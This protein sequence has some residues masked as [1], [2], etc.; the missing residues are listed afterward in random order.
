[1]WY[2]EVDQYDFKRPGF[3]GSTGHFTQL[4][5]VGTTKVG[6][7]RSQCKGNDI[8]VCNYDPPGNV[9]TA[10]EANVLPS[11]CKQRRSR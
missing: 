7:G 8:V 3:D 9:M 1:M 5:W 2:R 11:S 10:F 6:C 4:V